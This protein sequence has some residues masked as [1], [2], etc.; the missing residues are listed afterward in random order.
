MSMDPNAMSQLL[1]Q[2]L[3][4]SPQANNYG[5]GQTPQITA[6]TS[7]LAGGAQLA[8]KLMLM[9]ALQ[10]AKAPPANPSAQQMAATPGANM[11]GSTPM[12]PAGQALQYDAQG[13]ITGNTQLPTAS[14]LAPSMAATQL[15]SVPTVLDAVP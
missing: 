3:M 7:P 8:Q 2:Q 6:R 12:A 1:A 15:Q 14:Q 10:N 5:S 13:N 4:Q 11:G 9:R